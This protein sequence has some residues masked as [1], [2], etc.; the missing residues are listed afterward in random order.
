MAISTR[1]AVV[2]ERPSQEFVDATSAPPFLC[3]LTPAEARKVLNDVQ[4]EFDRCWDPP[5]EA[6]PSAP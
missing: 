5:A 4:A 3:E 1:T 2:L 6:A